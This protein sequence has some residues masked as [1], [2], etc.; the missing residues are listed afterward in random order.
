MVIQPDLIYVM[1]EGTGEARGFLVGGSRQGGVWGL[2]L[3]QSAPIFK[4]L[5]L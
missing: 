2:V 5:N 1:F 3:G 4:F